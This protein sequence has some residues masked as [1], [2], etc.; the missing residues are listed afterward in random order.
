MRKKLE[1]RYPEWCEQS[2]NYKK[3]LALCLSG[4][5]VQESAVVDDLI[6]D[7]VVHKLTVDSLLGMG[8]FRLKEGRLQ[9]AYVWFWA[10]SK[11]AGDL[12]GFSLNDYIALEK[13]N[14]QQGSPWRSMLATLGGIQHKLPNAEVICIEGQDFENH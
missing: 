9:C 2:W 11:L 12:A 5:L 6:V 7:G 13:K 8:L 1:D 3:A 4:S 10:L 14:Q